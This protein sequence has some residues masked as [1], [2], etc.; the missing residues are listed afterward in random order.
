MNAQAA[1][2]GRAA[3]IRQCPQPSRMPPSGG[4]R[5]TAANCR[6]GR[7]V[8][9]WQADLETMVEAPAGGQ[10]LEGTGRLELELPG[11]TGGGMA[12]PPIGR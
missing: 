1:L 6:A 11:G 4:V 12:G 10:A 8:A 7:R 5:P 9:G 2:L 3:A